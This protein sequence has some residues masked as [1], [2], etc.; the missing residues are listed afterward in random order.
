MAVLYSP[1]L[2]ASWLDVPIEWVCWECGGELKWPAVYWL[3]ARG[4]MLFDAAGAARLAPHLLMDSR[5]AELAGSP[6]PQWRGRVAAAMR[7]RLKVAEHA[8]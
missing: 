6:E 4:L 5:E 1:A 3:G 2:A 7:H 8:A